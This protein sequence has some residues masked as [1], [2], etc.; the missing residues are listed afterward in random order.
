M[1]ILDTNVVSEFMRV[2]PD[3]RVVDWH[4]HQASGGMFVT[5]V[6][7]AEV[8]AGV[9]ILPAGKRRDQLRLLAKGIFGE[10][11]KDRVLPFES[12]AASCYALMLAERRQR[13]KPIAPLDAQIAAIARSRRA[14]V[15]T[16][17]TKDFEDCGI[18]L[19]D[20]WTAI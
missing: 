5:S 17:N 16:R 3:R 2:S 12:S 10:D 15:V 14:T 7:E 1:M 8:L 4:R 9:E 20:P 18:G 19:V 6:T 13:G 11:F